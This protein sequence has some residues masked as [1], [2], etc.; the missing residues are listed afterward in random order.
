M[1]EAAAKADPA[2]AF[3]LA[4]RTAVVTGAS[5]GLGHAIAR[6]L[7]AAGAVVALN[8]RHERT[9][10][11]ACRALAAEGIEAVPLP[12]DVADGKAG[13]DAIAAFHDRRGR[14]DILVHNAG[15]PMRAPFLDHE[16]GDWQAVLDVHL[17]AAFRL[18][19]A[20]ARCM[21]A[22]GYGRIVFTSSI[23]ASVGRATVPAY[24][25]AKGGMNALL[26]SMAAELGPAGI[27]VNA[28]APGYIATELTRPLYDDEAFNAFVCRRTPAGRWGRPEE[29]GMAALYL[30]S[31]AAA[32]VN[33]HVLTVD[34][35]MTVSLA[36]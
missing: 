20:A 27:T 32:Y 28:I 8:G 21:V 30:A 22:A 13:G 19:Q 12:F 24:S 36:G 5:R 15:Q 33:G 10:E 31:E 18:G 16:P 1:P 34:G 35:G 25:A 29:V 7:G 4:G 17:T 23:L 26:R 9:L 14:L 3:S 2:Q 6:A 11:R